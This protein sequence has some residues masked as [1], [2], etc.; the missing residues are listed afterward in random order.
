[1]GEQISGCQRLVVEERLIT[2]GQ[3]EGILLVMELFCITYHDTP[4]S[5]YT[6]LCIFQNP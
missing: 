3:N 6:T 1:M 5:G 4:G 2:K